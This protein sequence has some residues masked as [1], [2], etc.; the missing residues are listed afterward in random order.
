M[1]PISVQINSEIGKLKA[2]IVHSPGAEVENMTPENAK[3]A[4]YSDILNLSIAL[5]EYRDFLGV[6]KKHTQ[7]FEVKELLETVVEKEDARERLIAKVCQ[8]ETHRHEMGQLCREIQD[9]P[10]A[11]LARQLMEGVEMK[12]DNL[13]RFLDNE[14]FCLTPLPN[15]FFT[16][17]ASFSM[18]DQVIIS[19]MANAVRDREALIMESI[20]EDHPLFKGGTVN[21]VLKFDQSG[22]G[23]IEGG[24]VLIARE[25]VFVIGQGDRTSTQGIDSMIEFLKTKEGVKHILVQELPFKPESFIHLDMTF[26]FLDKDQCMI[27]EPL[28]LSSTKHLTIH[29]TI[30]G[31]KVSRIQEERDLLD[32][33][34]KLGVDL[35]PVFCG[36][37]D[38]LFV[39]EREQWQSGANFF[40]LE[41]G[42]VMGYERNTHTIEALSRHGFEIVNA[43]DVVSG[44]V[45]LENY[46]KVV[47]TIE[48]N[49]L[50]RGGG[51][52]RCMTMPVAREKV[53]W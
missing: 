11:E 30:D 2:V 23:T 18:G 5:P 9:M 41:P 31:D 26:T 21:P 24:D 12:K 42:K 29:I 53:D 35:D 49:E 33:L 10:S 15:F 3:R 27:F 7:V 47:V 34:K 39:M 1:E 20:F 25:D 17:D 22:R 14:R 45:R 37:D 52:A 13:T 38:D 40:A 6:L 32:S 4:L 43:K 50:S 8:H 16:R 28:I 48:G 36:G 46:K 44:K 51:G 19:K